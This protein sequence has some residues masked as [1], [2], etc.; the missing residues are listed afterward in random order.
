MSGSCTRGGGLWSACARSTR[1]H[2]NDEREKGKAIVN[3]PSPGQC[4]LHSKGVRVPRLHSS[5]PRAA[6]ARPEAD[7]SRRPGCL[8]KRDRKPT[9]RDGP[10]AYRQE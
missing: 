1:A 9:R 5:S 3:L 4:S 6:L 8:F 10:G 7:A 2:G